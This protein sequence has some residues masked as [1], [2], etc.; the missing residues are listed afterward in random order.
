MVGQISPFTAKGTAGRAG[1]GHNLI[2]LQRCL[3]ATREECLTPAGQPIN[4]RA[5]TSYDAFSFSPL[6]VAFGSIVFAS[7]QSRE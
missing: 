3:H 1:K 6:S 5:M 7:N 2:I 4:C